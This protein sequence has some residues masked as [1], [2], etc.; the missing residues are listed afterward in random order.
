METLN[1]WQLLRKYQALIR[2]GTARDFLCPECNKRLVFMKDQYDE[3]VMYCA[4][5]D[6][7]Y[8]PG[9]QFWSDVRAVV[10]EHEE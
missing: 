9:S 1:H 5:E 8:I 7:G 10:M 3:P 2:V 4:W 6:S